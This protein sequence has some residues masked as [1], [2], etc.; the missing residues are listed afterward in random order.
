MAKKITLDIEVNG[1]MQKATVSVKKLRSA[2]DDVDQAQDRVGKSAR[3]QDRNMK[4]AAR[5]TSNSTKEFSKMA[6]GMGGLVGAYATVAAS[7]FALSAA[8]QF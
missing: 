3:T 8:F 7:V 1:K 4:G 6:Q 2:L 5:T